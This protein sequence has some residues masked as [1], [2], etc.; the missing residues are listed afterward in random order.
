MLVSFSD[1]ISLTILFVLLFPS[2]VSSRSLESFYYVTDMSSFMLL[3]NAS[4]Y[5]SGKNENIL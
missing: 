1:L 2:F 3:E 4:K 5:E